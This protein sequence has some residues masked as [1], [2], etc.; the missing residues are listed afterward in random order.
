ML[1]KGYNQLKNGQNRL[2]LGISYEG[3]LI[4]NN[5]QDKKIIAAY[6]Y[7]DI[8]SVCSSQIDEENLITVTL[9]K[10]C[11]QDQQAFRYLTFETMQ[12]ED[13]AS[14]IYS[15]APDLNRNQNAF[16]LS[17]KSN[18]LLQNNSAD[19]KQQANGRRLLKMTLEDR[20]KIHQDL[21]N[22]RKIIIE[23]GILRK[24][25]NAQIQENKGFM[26]STLRRLN[27]N[28][29]DK[30]HQ[31]I[32]FSADFEADCFQFYP[33][34]FWSFSK[35]PITSSILVTADSELERTAIQSFNSILKYSGLLMTN[36][37]QSSQQNSP[38]NS[39][40]SSSSSML[41]GSLNHQNS[42]DSSSSSPVLSTATSELNQIQLAQL[43]IHRAMHKNS[44]DIFK[45]ELFLQLI[46]QTTDHPEPNSKV[47]IKNW[48]LLALACSVT[49][50]TDRKVLALLKAHL[51]R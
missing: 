23:S 21:M 30:I 49:Y 3:I 43:I 39:I 37:Q 45:N 6:R 44:S 27:K 26:K 33:H 20:M 17:R 24:P 46:K 13:I 51:K 18:G 15:Y 32:N 22:C 47:N 8:E 35:Q 29:L 9:S 34:S 50:P 4:L 42:T 2:L 14:L 16:N 31:E 36:S 7:S 5:L 38:T 48:Q 19:N 11:A 1:Y 25:E 10:Q 40:N 28:K 41:N 12:K